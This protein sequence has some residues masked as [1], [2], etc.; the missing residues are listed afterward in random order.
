MRIIG[1]QA[2][3]R[4]LLEPERTSAIRPTSDR[5]RE[6]I[7]NIL[8][9]WCDGMS[10]LDL[11]AGTGAMGLEALSR[12]ATRATFVDSHRDATQLVRDNAQALGFVAQCEVMAQQTSDALRTLARRGAQF[13]LVFI[14][15]PYAQQQGGPTLQQLGSAGLL[16]P[17]S[18]VVV[19]GDK[20]EELAEYYGGLALTGSRRIGRTA[21]SIFSFAGSTHR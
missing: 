18:K 21:V 19:E 10:V 3:G 17:Q 16:F 1:G 9:Q 20:R 2:R 5:A 15:P 8:G 4:R 7:F 11:F 13:H 12:G 14:D 6:T